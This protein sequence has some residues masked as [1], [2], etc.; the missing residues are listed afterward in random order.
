VSE[1]DL[2]WRK[3][4][5]CTSGECVEVAYLGDRVI[6]RNSGT[7]WVC[8]YSYRPAWQAF[9]AAV[10]VPRHNGAAENAHPPA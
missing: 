3:R 10:A 2:R 6:V 4:T 9:I 7:P 5:A 8:L 1:I